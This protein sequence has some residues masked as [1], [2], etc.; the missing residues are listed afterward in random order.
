MSIEF[1]A[2]Q[3]SGLNLM[4]NTWQKSRMKRY[5]CGSIVGL[6]FLTG[7]LAFAQRGAL[8]ASSSLDQLTRQA[9][10][11][12]R[13]HITSARV[14]P[15]PQLSNLMTVVI[16]MSIQQTL[17]GRAQRTMEFR[18]YIWD[19]RDQ[20]DAASYSKGDELLLMLGPVSQFGL[21]SPVGL[22]QGRFRVV[23][24]RQGKATAVNGRANR[25]LFD[26][27]AQRAQTQGIKLPARTTAMLRRPQPGPLPLAEL[28][29]A[30]RAFARGN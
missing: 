2:M 3:D 1:P 24:D 23:R 14:E 27:T 7:T 13:G 10:V 30:I 26:S 8:T 17:K 6:A 16:S 18:Q 11:I 19:I 15:H 28:E 25:G 22:E 21:T 9:R 20:L 5:L 12:V 29:E 4:S